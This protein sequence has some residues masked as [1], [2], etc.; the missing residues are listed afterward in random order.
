MTSK[1]TE[2]NEEHFVVKFDSGTMCLP[3]FEDAKRL[4]DGA[5]IFKVMVET[6]RIVEHVSGEYIPCFGEF[7]VDAEL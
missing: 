3:D 2:T 1:I 7:P 4:A 6:K 5:P